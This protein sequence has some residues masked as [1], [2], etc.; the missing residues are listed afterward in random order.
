MCEQRMCLPSVKEIWIK[1]LLLQEQFEFG[2]SC[3]R[4]AAQIGA[5]CS[6]AGLMGRCSTIC[7]PLYKA[8]LISDMLPISNQL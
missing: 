2:F 5:L 3:V 7:F 6:A 8:Q 4:H 1:Y